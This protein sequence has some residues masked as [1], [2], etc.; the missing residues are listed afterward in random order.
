M[1]VYE[2]TI[3]ECMDDGSMVTKIECL[4]VIAGRK[5][6]VQSFNN[7][8]KQ[9]CEQLIRNWKG[10]TSKRYRLHLDL[11]GSIYQEYN[12]TRHQKDILIQKL[13]VTLEKEWFNTAE[14]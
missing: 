1:D 2:E 6:D 13:E 8:T 3:S 12:F 9:I 10:K 5:G 11:G 14:E 7:L 4:S